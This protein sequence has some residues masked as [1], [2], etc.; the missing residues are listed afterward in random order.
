MCHRH[1]AVVQ[2]ACLSVYISHT[3]AERRS[4]QFRVSADQCP[5]PVGGEPEAEQEQ[6]HAV[7][8]Q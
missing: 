8:G 3:Q 7:Q 2:H 1:A 5:A 4:G 6:N